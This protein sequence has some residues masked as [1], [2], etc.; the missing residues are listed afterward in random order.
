MIRPLVV[1]WSYIKDT[2]KQIWKIVKRLDITMGPLILYENEFQ[3]ATELGNL[4]KNTLAELW[5]NIVFW[6]GIMGKSRFWG[7]IITTY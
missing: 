4:Y 1:L 5:E 7:G 6:G 2:I 3:N